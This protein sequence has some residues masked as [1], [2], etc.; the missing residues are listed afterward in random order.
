MI[1]IGKWNI[2]NGPSSP[3]PHC[4]GNLLKIDTRFLPPEE[5]WLSSQ[6][7]LVTSQSVPFLAFF[8]AFSLCPTSLLLPQSPAFF[9]STPFSRL[10]PLLFVGPCFFYLR[11][12]LAL[13]S[14]PVL[15]R[16]TAENN[17]YIT[18]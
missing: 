6:S 14:V 17:I 15:S 7:M 4:K 3:K 11:L 16:M 9:F 5:I 10:W 18:Y 12:S 1:L 2:F 13:L 8:S